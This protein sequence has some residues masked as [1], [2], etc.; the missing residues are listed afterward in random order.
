MVKPISIPASQIASLAILGAEIPAHFE[1]LGEL[2]LLLKAP[3]PPVAVFCAQRCPD[4]LHAVAQQTAQALRDSGS[5]TISGFFTPLES[6]M[7]DILLRGTQPVIRVEV[8][9]LESY[10]LPN[11]FKRPLDKGRLLILSPYPGR[12]KPDKEL[13]EE[14]NRIAAALAGRLLVIHAE[15]GGKLERLCAEAAREWGKPVEAPE[16]FYNT[17]LVSLGVKLLRFSDSAS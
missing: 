8:R 9:G 12:R 6:Q 5:A 14:R 10:P 13:A 2:D 11:Q 4:T 16:S 7:F 1:A 15:P 3:S 17:H